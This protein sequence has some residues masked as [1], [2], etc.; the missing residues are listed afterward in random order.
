MSEYY[1]RLEKEVIK[2][3]QQ[4][5]KIKKEA[6]SGLFEYRTVKNQSFL[7]KY[8]NQNSE[9]LNHARKQIETINKLQSA[10]KS[11]NL[12]NDDIVSTYS[13]LSDELD[14]LSYSMKQIGV[15]SSKTLDPGVANAGANKVQA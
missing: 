12:S 10:L 1:T 8:T 2:Q 13:K 6:E 5:T 15:E 14:K 7:D 9:A 3:Q 4:I 11:E